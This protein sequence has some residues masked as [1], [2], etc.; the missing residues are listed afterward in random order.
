MR[1]KVL[2]TGATGLIGKTLL[3]MLRA[4]GHDIHILSRSR[5]QVAGAKVFVWDLDAGTADPAAFAG[6]DAIIHLAGE[7]VGDK[8][9]SES[10]KQKILQSRT[11]SAELLAGHVA[12]QDKK[13]S[14]FITA[15]GSSYYGMVTRTRPF[16]EDEGPGEGFLADVSVAWEKAADLFKSLV[17]RVVKLRISVVF[18]P[19][20]GPLHKMA[21]PVKMG[22]AAVV[23]GSGRQ[24][25]PWIHVHDVC[26]LMMKAL[27]DEAMNGPYNLAA[28]E[29][30][31]NRVFTKELASV[32]NRFVLPF[33]APAFLLKVGLGEQSKLLLEG[34]PLSVDKVLAT[35]YTYRFPGLREALT[36]CLKK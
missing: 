36:D 12:A 20:G 33:P 18:S 23:F 1:M 30:P 13:P 22:G 19:E 9:W 35:G 32:L 17:P 31:D 6:V 28:P 4:G 14:V 27:N 34:S 15:S 24:Y 8:G 3:P 29:Q 11:R 21:K 16:T 26:S 7:N 5:Q 10:Q 25:M 2:V